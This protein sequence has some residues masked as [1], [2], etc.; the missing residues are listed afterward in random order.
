M[1]F[2]KITNRGGV[3]KSIGKFPS[4]TQQKTIWYEGQLEKDYL[5]LL[6]FDFVDV[7]EVSEQACRF[8]YFVEG[9]RRRYTADFLVKRRNK[10]QVVEVKI[11]KEADLEEN[12]VKYRVAKQACRRRGFEFIVVTE[13]V[14]RLQ[15]RLDNIKLL[16]HYQRV[17][18]YGQHQ[19]LCYEFFREREVATLEEVI[20]YLTRNGCEKQITYSLLRW[21]VLRTDLDTSIVPE[22]R[23]YCQR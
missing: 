21:G 3:R 20:D 4:F 2:R 9:K 23:I 12:I 1:G 5:Y 16:I 18:I 22:S 14:I 13:H 6:E 10:I 7:M 11:K 19:I 8:F 15:P 17:P